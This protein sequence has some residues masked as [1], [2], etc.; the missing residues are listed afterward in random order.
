MAVMALRIKSG[1]RAQLNKN[2]DED[3]DDDADVYSASFSI[4]GR[5]EP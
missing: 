4:E 2:D 1:T 3:D 5:G